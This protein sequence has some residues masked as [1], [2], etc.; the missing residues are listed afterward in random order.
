MTNPIN[1][2]FPAVA[3]AAANIGSSSTHM[4]TLLGD[5]DASV[6]TRLQQCWIGEGGE[7]YQAIAARWNAAAAD[8]RTALHQL[9]GAT[10]TAGEGM[11]QTNRANA[12]RFALG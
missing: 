9:S 7:S 5:M 6:R 3:A 4:E 10:A 8:L 11:S 2:N 12:A 1:Y